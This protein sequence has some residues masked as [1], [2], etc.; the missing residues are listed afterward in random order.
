MHRMLEKRA[1]ILAMR[2]RGASYD[3]IRDALQVGA[4]TISA[5]IKGT[6]Y[7]P[8]KP[9]PKAGRPRKVM[10]ETVVNQARAMLAAGNSIKH[11]A[12]VVGLSGR[13]V[14]RI[15]REMGPA[16]PAPV[17]R[18]WRRAVEPAPPGAKFETIEEYLA[19]GGSITR[20][21]CAFTNGLRATASAPVPYAGQ[22]FHYQDHRKNR[23]SRLHE[24][25]RGMG[26]NG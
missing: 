25:A 18:R 11:T 23:V 24:I 1:R 15:R 5:A 7:A 4:S 2:A 3:E 6:P 16:A 22:A 17:K 19:R 9:G 14:K 13:N 26:K 20:C 10:D 12:A 8:K 21:P